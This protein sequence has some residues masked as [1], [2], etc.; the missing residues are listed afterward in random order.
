MGIP[1]VRGRD[2]GLRDEDSSSHGVRAIVISEWSAKKLFGEADPIGQRILMN[3][4]FEIVGVAKDIKYSSLREAPRFVFY[5]P[6]VQRPSPFRT[7]FAVKTTGSIA[8]LGT[9]L[10]AIVA[11]IDPQAHM[12]GMRTIDERLDEALSSERL[13]A[14]LAGFFG[15]AALALSAMGLFGLISY[16]VNARTQEIGIRMALGAPVQRI[17]LMVV[18]QGFVLALVGCAVGIAGACAVTRLVASLLYGI[19][20]IDWLTF[21][22]AAM[23]LLLVTL[24]ACA[25]P[26]WRAAK[27]NPAVALR[28]E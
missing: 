18:R 15:L 3:M 17:L 4:E 19:P 11:Q 25:I 14:H 9:S 1:L 26:A 21:S 16:N 7:T 24:L 5:L 13:I 22:A 27:V 6:L 28:A 23:L 10:R 20:S 8:S 2:F 12:S